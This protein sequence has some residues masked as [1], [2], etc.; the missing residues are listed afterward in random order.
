[1]SAIQEFYDKYTNSQPMALGQLAIERVWSDREYQQALR[2]KENLE[3]LMNNT[4]V[5]RN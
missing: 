1:M 2:N 4:C 3:R 5:C